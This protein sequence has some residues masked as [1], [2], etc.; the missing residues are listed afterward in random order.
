MPNGDLDAQAV[1]AALLAEA[2]VVGPEVAR[3]QRFERDLEAWD[4][5]SGDTSA[6][7]C[8]IQ[9]YERH[10]VWL[11]E[12]AVDPRKAAGAYYTPVAIARGA[13]ALGLGPLLQEGGIPR[14]LDPACGAG[15]FLL[16]VWERLWPLAA[17]RLGIDRAAAQRLVAD[18]HLLGIEID[19]NA[20]TAARSL[21]AT[22]AGRHVGGAD[23]AAPTIRQADALLDGPAALPP[24][25]I[26]AVVGNPPFLNQLE[27]RT[28]RSTTRR[29]ALRDRWG[30][31]PA[32]YADEAALFQLAGLS[33]VREGGTSTLLGPISILSARDAAPMRQRLAQAGRIHGFWDGG[34]RVFPGVQAHICALSFRRGEVAAEAVACFQGPAFAP[35]GTRPFDLSAAGGGASWAP[36]AAALRG[37]AVPT[38]EGAG[39]FGDIATITADFRDQYYGLVGRIVEAAAGLDDAAFPPLLTSG[40][41][42]LAATRWGERATRH[43]GHGW[44]RPCVDLAALSA[45]PGLQGWAARRLVPKVLVAT[46]RAI[47]ASVVDAGG[48]WLPS[49]PVLSA[50]P[51][52]QGRLWHL[53]AAISAPPVVALAASRTFGSALSERAIKLSAREL[54]ALPRPADAV[55]WDRGA[56][57]FQA[58]Q[59]APD[60]REALAA[61]WAR[62]MC[63]AYRV[64]K[65]EQG[66]L[67]RWWW[68][69]WTGKEPP[70]SVTDP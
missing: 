53:A 69:R 1:R 7:W 11:A 44:D 23:E 55:A 58:M 47:L 45:N 52:D 33:W 26:D 46:Q 28:A 12:G 64:P 56:R 29:R 51:F 20:A 24:W 63:D 31:P 22:L 40:A 70:N 5:D 4:R 21:L 9:G 66:S 54:R 48:R 27:R 62:S 41:V 2:A 61:A 14:V 36:F 19:P 15:A 17:E 25:T 57:A 30:L 43:A 49:V 65:E 35:A 37:H 38:L 42:D 59:E 6:L 10:S 8:A 60:Q 34:D 67:L 16:A 18:H 32:G 13:V 50:V 3:Q 39:S 68:R